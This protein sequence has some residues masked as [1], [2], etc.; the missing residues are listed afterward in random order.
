MAIALALL[1]GIGVI[2]CNGT[3]IRLHMVQLALAKD[4]RPIRKN[5]RNLRTLDLGLTFTLNLQNEMMRTVETHRSAVF[6]LFVCCLRA[7]VNPE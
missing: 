6:G 2:H 3:S 7:V 5:L 1:G 4:S